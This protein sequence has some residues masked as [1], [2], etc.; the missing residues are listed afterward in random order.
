W[1]IAYEAAVATN[2][3]SPADEGA[4]E[5][6]EALQ[7]SAEGG[8]VDVTAT[9]VRYQYYSA[10][11]GDVLFM[12]TEQRFW[13]NFCTAV[14]RIDLLDRWPGEGYSDHAYGDTELRDELARIFATRTRAE[15]ID[16]FI[17]HD[18]AGAPVYR[19]GE[20]H[21]DPHFNARN[22]WTD[23]NVHGLELL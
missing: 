5:L 13:R 1:H 18:V 8:P 2:G 9:D 15:W 19:A 23:G 11:D 4:R 10:K 6:V 16:M 20:T 21:A 12:A 7:A 3:E 22:L 14:D 17:E